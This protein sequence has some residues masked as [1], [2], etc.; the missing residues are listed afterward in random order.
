MTPAA[1]VQAAIEVLDAILAGKPAEQAL[2]GWARGA[3]YAG[4]KDRAAVR[5]HVFQ[6]LR[7]RRSYAA[8][9]G[10]ETGRGLMIGQLRTTSACLAD[11]FSGIGHAPDPINA[12]EHEAG[13]SPA[14]GPEALDLPDW[15]WPHFSAALTEAGAVSAARHLQARAPVALRVNLRVN[16]VS[17]AIE[18]LKEDGISTLPVDGVDT[19]LIVTD[20]ARRIKTSRAYL[21]GAVELQDVASQAA[22]AALD[23]APGA[24]VLDLCAGGGGKTLALAARTKA[25]WH[26]HDAAP[27]RLR[28]LPARADRAGVTI[29]LLDARGPEQAAPFDVVLCDVPCSGSGTW[30]RA[31]DAKWRLS[32]ADLDRFTT[33]QRTILD[34]AQALVRPGG[35]LVYTTCSVF[36]AEN[37]AASDGFLQRYPAWHEAMR[38]HWPITAEQ[39]GFYLSVF[40]AP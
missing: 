40:L 10:A 8:R 19:G 7:C 1:R 26:A 30:R 38:R 18:N 6:A 29:D 22:M 5:D 37:S 34:R 33:T 21:G 36:E 4:S 35:Q 28:D 12:K 15:M 23:I 2:T 20:G 32:A 11:I 17:E 31:P 14:P 25:L 13:R 39:D 16:S 9:G 24:K 27:A 3:R